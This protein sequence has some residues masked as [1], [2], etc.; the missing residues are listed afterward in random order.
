MLFDIIHQTWIT[1]SIF[2]FIAISIPHPWWNNWS[3]SLAIFVVSWILFWRFTFFLFW[4]ERLS[5]FTIYERY[6]R[7][8][9]C[10]QTFNWHYFLSYY[11]LKSR[12][13]YWLFLFEPFYISPMSLAYYIY[14]KLHIIFRYP[15]I[16]SKEVCYSLS[17]II[18]NVWL[19][20]YPP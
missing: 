10:L 3:S 14:I 16:Q 18:P 15:N 7:K 12:R 5:I 11:F 17:G 13:F 8:C 20:F 6:T 19:L 1:L 2:I 4:F 9:I